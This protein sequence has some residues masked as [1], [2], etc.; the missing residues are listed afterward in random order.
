M[1]HVLK[2]A[3]KREEATS[4]ECADA[5]ADAFRWRADERE[6]LVPYGGQTIVRNR[7]G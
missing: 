4:T 5:V 7:V 2:H 6:Q 3:A 1:L